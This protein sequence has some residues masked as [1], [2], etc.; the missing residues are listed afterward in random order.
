M[1]FLAELRRRNVIR[2]G[3]AYLVAAWLVVQVVE[4]I[5]P[6]FEMA[7]VVRVVVIGFA[8]GFVPVLILSWVFELT[9]AARL[10][11]AS[12]SSC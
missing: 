7:W 4:T 1:S 3:A 9:P 6:A 2:V 8:I 10:S 12:S 5:A 11:I